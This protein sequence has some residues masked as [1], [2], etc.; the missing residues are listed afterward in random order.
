MF[1]VEYVQNVEKLIT[2]HW[3]H[4]RNVIVVGLVFLKDLANCFLKSQNN[5]NESTLNDM[6]WGAKR[7][8]IFF[9]MKNSLKT[10]LNM[11]IV[12]MKNT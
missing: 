9:G 1:E 8:N 12:Y 7:L 3:N 4:I 6:F 2:L 5:C 10:V 11:I